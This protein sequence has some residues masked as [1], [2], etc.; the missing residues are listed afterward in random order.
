LGLPHRSARLSA[1]PLN[2][3]VGLPDVGGM[4]GPSR[5]GGEGVVKMESM[6]VDGEPAGDVA[7]LKDGTAEPDPALPSA[8]EP[9][10]K[11]EV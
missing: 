4:A 10:T 1:S 11:Q 8:N 9:S 7:Q 2:P 6:E 5:D 3:T